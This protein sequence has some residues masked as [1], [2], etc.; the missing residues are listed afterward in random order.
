MVGE[1]QMQIILPFITSVIF[2]VLGFGTAH[3]CTKPMSSSQLSAVQSKLTEM[4]T[5]E[6]NTPT[7]QYH[8]KG[9]F[10][11]DKCRNITV[12]YGS[13]VTHGHLTQL[14]TELNSSHH[15]SAYFGLVKEDEWSVYSSDGILVFHQEELPN[16]MADWLFEMNRQA[17]ELLYLA[18]YQ[19]DPALAKREDLLKHSIKT[20][21][22]PQFSDI[23]QTTVDIWRAGNQ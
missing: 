11:I 9:A 10:Q 15:R 8:H 16:K 13:N 6:E 1:L 12:K 19:S 22:R 14:F 23:F 2:L 18:G 3:A 4:M 21:G 5:Y 7:G 20:F 17:V